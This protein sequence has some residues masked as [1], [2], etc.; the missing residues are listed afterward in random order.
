MEFRKREIKKEK[1]SPDISQRL[2]NWPD[3]YYR[4]RD[5]SIRKQLLDAADEN[6]LTPEDNAFRRR[7]FEIR[8]PNE[9]SPSK[10]QI[11]NYLKAWM[12]LR[13]LDSDTGGL[14]RRKL[15]PVRVQKVLSEMGYD[16]P[17]NKR[18]ENLL[19]Q[20]LYHL[21]MLYI[22]L[23]QEDKNFNALFL[24]IGTISETTQAK[25]IASEY[26]T[27]AVRVMKKFHAEEAGALFSRAVLQAY[28]DMFPDYA[29]L[30]LQSEE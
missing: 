2:L 15:V 28:E 7:L 16:L 22:A 5:A 23:C 25:K 8:Y 29:D 18:E 14:F 26:R 9:G 20:E 24:G 13:F 12:D 11:D 27:V 3:C 1:N 6:G 21:G 19:Y 10:P 4:E 30:P 17:S